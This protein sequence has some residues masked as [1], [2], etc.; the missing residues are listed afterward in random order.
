M[1]STVNCNM[2]QD[3]KWILGNFVTT[4]NWKYF[5]SFVNIKTCEII[6]EKFQLKQKRIDRIEVSEGKVQYSVFLELN[7]EFSLSKEFVLF[8]KWKMKIKIPSNYNEV[9]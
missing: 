7:L 5:V 3:I 9:K 2:Y 8:Q 4:L 1:P 6:Q